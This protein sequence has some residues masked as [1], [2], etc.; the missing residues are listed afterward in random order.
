MFI[1][2]IRHVALRKKEYPVVR[3]IV[4]VNLEQEEMMWLRNLE[5]QLYKRV[6]TSGK[7]NLR[8]AFVVRGF[9]AFL[10]KKSA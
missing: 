6:H 7:K 4:T 5:T 10:A 1:E 3:G 8:L 9:F 2:L